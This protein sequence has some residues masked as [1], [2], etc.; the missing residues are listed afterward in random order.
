MDFE[1]LFGPIGKDACIY[2]Y[3]LSVISAIIFVL[4][5]GFLVKNIMTV[6]K[7][8]STQLHFIIIMMQSALAYFVNRVLNTMCVRTLI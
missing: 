6:G 2:F 1:S 8:N 7:I 3:A 4:S 5:F